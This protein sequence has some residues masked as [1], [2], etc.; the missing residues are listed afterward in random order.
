M[1]ARYIGMGY[2]ILYILIA[3]IDSSLMRILLACVA[4]GGILL[5]QCRIV[6]AILYSIELDS[7][8]RRIIAR[9]NR[10]RNLTIWQAPRDPSEGDDSPR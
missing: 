3:L 6:N 1:N 4:A 10:A 2:A 7:Q 8:R 5:W 9:L